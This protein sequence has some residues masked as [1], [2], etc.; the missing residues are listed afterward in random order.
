M[1]QKLSEV[2]KYLNTLKQKVEVMFKS[3]ST[4]HDIW[5]L[6][7]VTNLAINIA[8]NYKESN[9]VVVAIAAYLHDLHRLMQTKQGV[10][11]NPKQSLPQ[12]LEIL[13]DL[14]LTKDVVDEICYCIEHHENYNWNGKN[15]K[16][17]NA[18]IVQDADNLDALGAIGI[19]RCFTYGGANSMPM[20]NPDVP[21][22][23]NND[24]T[25]FSGNDAS[26]IH[27]FYHKLFKLEDNMNTQF[28]KKLA[29]N[30]TKFLHKYT[31]Q[32]LDEWQGNK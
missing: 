15:V 7:R 32:F 23:T 24:Y 27:H 13:K 4:G 20:Y 26:T 31:T 28:A 2:N 16:N 12:V 8:L 3:E 21:L 22:N 19:A 11:I 10:T 9:I 5:H 30:R 25:E 29:K 14:K 1:E 17:I 18:L 6:N